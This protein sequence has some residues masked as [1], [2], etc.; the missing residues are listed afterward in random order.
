M[1]LVLKQLLTKAFFDIITLQ[2]LLFL[3]HHVLTRQKIL[4]SSSGCFVRTTSGPPRKVYCAQ[5][6]HSKY[7]EA[8]LVRTLD[9][10][11]VFILK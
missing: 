8:L 3:F 10:S 1:I 9:L 7:T 5:L 11:V 2:H 6:V 4:F